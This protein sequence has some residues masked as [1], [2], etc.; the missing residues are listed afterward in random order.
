M[1]SSLVKSYVSRATFFDELSS[2]GLAFIAIK[3]ENSTFVSSQ[4]IPNPSLQS[5]DEVVIPENGPDQWRAPKFFLTLP[6][7]Q[8]TAH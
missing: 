3:K 5:K 2:A 4:P 6:R 7:S 1:N 8:R